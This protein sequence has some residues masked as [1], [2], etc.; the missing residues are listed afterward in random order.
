MEKSK[1]TKQDAVKMFEICRNKFNT[2]DVDTHLAKLNAM[3]DEQFTNFLASNS[4][5]T[6]EA[7]AEYVLS[8]TIPPQ[9]AD[10]N[11]ARQKMG[12]P[13]VSI[14]ETHEPAR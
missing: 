5:T 4:M 8:H 12:L 2:R 3:S 6:R 9:Y 13:T 10:H 11:V 7:V 14:G 1:V